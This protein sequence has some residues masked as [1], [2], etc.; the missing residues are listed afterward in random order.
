VPFC[1]W[2]QRANHS[3][4]RRATQTTYSRDKSTNSQLITPTRVRNPLTELATSPSAKF[5]NSRKKPPGIERQISSASTYI[6]TVLK[7]AATIWR[8]LS[9]LTRGLQLW[10]AMTSRS[11]TSRYSMTSTP[12]RWWQRRE[13]C[14]GYTER[15]IIIN[16]TLNLFLWIA[17]GILKI[18][19][20][21]IFRVLFDKIVSVYFSLKYIYRPVLALEMASPGNQHCASCIGT[22]SFL[23]GTVRIVCTAGSM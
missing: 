8:Q 18:S 12:R 20:R 3:A 23:I 10:R 9:T 19:N 5:C 16:S 21:N 13:S 6:T 22:L 15:K 11:M 14:D 7:H 1:A 4:T 17:V 2:V